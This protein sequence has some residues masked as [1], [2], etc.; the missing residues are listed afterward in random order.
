MLTCKEVT[1][2]VASGEIDDAS[3][4]QRALARLHLL[5]C[6]DCRRYVEELRALRLTA[7]DV[8]RT[9]LDPDHLA[10]LELR[11]FAL[12]Q[13]ADGSADPSVTRRETD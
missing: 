13:S 7:R 12:S 5:L 2:L 10:A 1:T 4:T 11:I 9:E 8:L 6:G 3:A